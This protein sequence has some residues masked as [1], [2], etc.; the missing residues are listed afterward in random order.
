MTSK[1]GEIDDLLKLMRED[2]APAPPKKDEPK[3]DDP[4]A[5][6]KEQEKKDKEDKEKAAKKEFATP[7]APVVDRKTE[8]DEPPGHKGTEL[9]RTPGP[10][11]GLPTKKTKDAD[12]KEK[13]KEKE[14]DD[15]EMYESL[16]ISPKAY[17][18]AVAECQSQAEF[19]EQY[20]NGDEKAFVTEVNEGDDPAVIEKK[21]RPPQA[22]FSKAV[23]DIEKDPKVDDP[24]AVAAHI[25][26]HWA[27]PKAKKKMKGMQ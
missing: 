1:L 25:W 5:K 10:G 21:E 20:R 17:A 7:V 12:D 14:K 27:G 15:E 26:Y 6:K 24:E 3:K 22:W 2:D 16:F 11:V 23:K 8:D 18:A 13:E 19:L 4:E 9:A